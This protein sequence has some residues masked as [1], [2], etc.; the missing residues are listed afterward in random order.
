MNGNKPKEIWKGVKS[1]D[2]SSDKARKS[3]I[4]LE[5]DLIIQFKVL[6]I[7]NIFKMFYSLR[8]SWRPPRKT[9]KS[10]QQ[11]YMSNTQKYYAVTYAMY[12]IT[13]NCQTYLKRSLKRFYLA[14][15]P[16]SHW[17]EQ[18]PSKISERRC[19][20]VGSSFQKF[21]KFINKTI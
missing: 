10:T 12:L 21:N 15:I 14:S 2:L 6:E 13:L 5:K 19:R 16:V 3:N 18:K 7:A 9:A 1:L 20:I 8:I 11:I 17:N 4:Y